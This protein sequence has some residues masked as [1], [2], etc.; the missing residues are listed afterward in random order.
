[1]SE[2]YPGKTLGELIKTGEKYN[3]EILSI[4][5]KEHRLGLSL[6][7]MNAKPEEVKEENLF[8]KI[9]SSSSLSFALYL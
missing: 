2:A 9:C 4:E 5:P 8:L 3:W 7:A 1:M 6:K